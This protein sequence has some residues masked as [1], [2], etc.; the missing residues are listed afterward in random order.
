MPL[1]HT[2]IPMFRL[3]FTTDKPAFI[4]RNEEVARMLRKFAKQIA[5]NP[6]S[7]LYAGVYNV[8]GKKIGRIILDK[9]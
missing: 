7:D 8:D 1:S 2:M 5:D 3:E 6:D 9:T 4:Q